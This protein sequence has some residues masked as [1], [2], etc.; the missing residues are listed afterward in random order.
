MTAMRSH[1]ASSSGKYELTMRTDFA[2]SPANRTL[3][4]PWSQCPA[5]D[6]H[7]LVDQLVDLRLAGDVDAARRLVEHQH[8]H[9]VM[10]QARERD[11]L[12]IAARQAS[13]LSCA[14]P[15]ARM[16]R[17]SIHRRARSAAAAPATRRSRAPGPSS[18]V[19]VMLSAMFR[20]VASP[21]PVRSSL[22]MPMPRRHQSAGANG[23]ACTP[24]FTDPLF[25]ASSPKSPRSRRVRPAPSRP[26]MP[27]IS[28]RCS[29][30]DAG[31]EPL[32]RESLELQQRLADRALARAD[33]GRRAR[34]RP[35]G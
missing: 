31:L 15:A 26:A 18:R 14:G 8:V 6:R 21:S 11:L 10:Q 17:R 3:R 2:A 4:S 29:V 27:R 5:A 24:S 25:T 30:N 35:S 33:R 28:P 9:V 19:R 22:S 1:S 32:G 7:Q 16:P 13:T 20:F 34:V 12:L 23:P